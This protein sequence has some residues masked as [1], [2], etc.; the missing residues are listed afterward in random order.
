MNITDEKILEKTYSIFLAS[1][2]ILQHQYRLRGCKKHSELISS[3][4]TEKNNELLIKNHQSHHI[5][6]AAFSEANI[7][8]SKNY[9][10]EYNHG[11]I[12]GREHDRGRGC[13]RSGYYNTS[14]SQSGYYN[15]SQNNVIHM[16]HHVERHDK[17]KD[18]HKNIL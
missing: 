12:H 10:R 2:I 13:G 9:G 8:F 5:G 11:R 7:V 3:L 17:R 1:N 6:S 18:V 4:V 15:P 16:K 14:K